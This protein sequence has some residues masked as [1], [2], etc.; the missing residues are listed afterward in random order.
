M[1]LTQL[2]ASCVWQ[3]WAS[4]NSL[5][6]G[7]CLSFHMT[8][9]WMDIPHFITL[10]LHPASILLLPQQTRMLRRVRQFL[11]WLKWYCLPWVPRCW[12]EILVFGRADDDYDDPDKECC[13]K[14][15]WNIQRSSAVTP[16]YMREEV[17]LKV[18]FFFK[19]GNLTTVWNYFTVAHFLNSIPY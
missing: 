2:I 14:L 8:S 12:G 4:H 1:R 19:K 16:K 11:L 17:T 3:M 13:S 7:I 15:A 18:F 9:W 6:T 5:H 10:P